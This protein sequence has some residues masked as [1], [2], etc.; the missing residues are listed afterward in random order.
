LV[1]GTNR[2]SESG[3]FQV[4]L[5]TGKSLMVA[6]NARAGFVSGDGRH[7]YFFRGEGT[8]HEL[9]DHELST[10]KERSLVKYEHAPEIP[11]SAYVSPDRTRVY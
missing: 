9:V 6:A 8:H 10:H 1:E 11:E 7:L 4:D 3:V 5:V 2:N